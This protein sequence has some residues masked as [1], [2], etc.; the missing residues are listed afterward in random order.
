ML[1]RTSRRTAKTSQY[2]R[3]RLNRLQ[4]LGEIIKPRFILGVHCSLLLCILMLGCA[5]TEKAQMSKPSQLASDLAYEMYT[6]EN[7][8]AAILNYERAISYSPNAVEPWIEYTMVLRRVN[9]LVNAARAGWRAV[10]LAPDD[11]AA[12]NN[13][14]N[15]LLNAHAWDG[16]MASFQKVEVLGKNRTLA[17]RNFVALGYEEWISGLGESAWKRF[18][19]ALKVDPQDGLA[20][21]L[22]G[23]ALACRS[24][25]NLSEAERHITRGIDMLKED[26]NAANIQYA[27]ALLEDLKAG[28]SLCP[29]WTPGISFQLLPPALESQP[30][31]GTALKVDVP[32]QVIRRYRLPE[33]VILSI[34]TP[35]IWA[36]SL[37]KAIS[38]A[39]FTVLF[40]PL[41][42]SGY[43]VRMS[44]L[45]VGQGKEDVR[46]VASS[47]INRLMKETGEERPELSPLKSETADGLAFV[48]THKTPPGKSG[49]KADAQ[50]TIGA[51]MQ[52]GSVYC[53]ITVLTKNKEPEF[54]NACYE[55]FKSCSTK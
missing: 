24:K 51:V 53:L 35:E 11:V 15:V 47:W 12:W 49:S 39:L 26:R 34:R 38:G 3:E 43:E 1:K 13:L 18:Q 37:D 16:A 44:P 28:R 17:A 8:R 45:G 5:S 42:G 31:R 19:Y 6:Q 21:V 52:A 23:A 30:G 2:S 20:L 4:A 32:S 7:Y 10:E 29:K 55:I 9:R 48:L 54:I 22:L 41:D 27:K 33:G 40:T 46:T 25:D 36:E 14:G 50:Y